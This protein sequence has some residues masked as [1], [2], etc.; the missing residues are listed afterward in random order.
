MARLSDA[1]VKAVKPGS[2][3]K[4]IYD[5]AE[6]GLCL[7]VQP[8]GQMAWGLRIRHAGRQPRYSLGDYPAT[9][10]AEARALAA[11]MK[12]AATRG[13]NPEVARPGSADRAHYGSRSDCDLPGDETEQQITRPRA[14]EVRH[15]CGACPRDAPCRGCHQG[16]DRIVA[17]RHRI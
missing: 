5:E 17:S 12:K 8:G 6:P 11:A 14:A 15:P 7:W 9:S 4:D 16:R 2:A 1:A 10:L 13:Q 3:T